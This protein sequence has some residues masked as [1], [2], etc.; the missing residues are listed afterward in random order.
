[1]DLINRGYD[2]FEQ[3]IMDDHAGIKTRTSERLDGRCV[4][5]KVSRSDG[6]RYCQ[7][8][9]LPAAEPNTSSNKS[10]GSSRS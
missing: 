7:P 10:S 2:D 9:M 6:R 8:L 1:M 3:K 5:Q 4:S